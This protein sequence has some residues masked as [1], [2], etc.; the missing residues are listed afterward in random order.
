MSGFSNWQLPSVV[1]C[2]RLIGLSM[3]IALSGCVAYKDIHTSASLAAPESFASARTLPAQGGVWPALDWPARVGGT[4]LQD[5]VDEALKDNPGLQAAQTRLAAA[6]A[7]ADATRAAAGLGIGASAN[8]TYQRYTEHG[9]IPPPLAGTMHSDNQVALNFSYDFDFWG[10]HAADLRAVIAQGKSV[11]AEHYNARLVLATAVAR[12]W[13]QLGRQNQQLALTAQQKQVRQHLDDLTQRRIAAGLD[14][15]SDRQ[16]SQ[17]QLEQLNAE[18]AQWQEAIALTR[19]QLAALLGKG[20]DRGADIQGPVP[21]GLLPLDLP[22]SLPLQLIGR[23]PDVVAA[24]WQVEAIQGEIA[25]ARAQFYPNVNLNAFVGLSSLG[26]SNLLR[27]GSLIAGVGPAIRLP[28]FENGTLR[29]QLKGKVASYDGAVASYNQSITQALQ[30]VADQM[31]SL[32]GVA[33]QNQYQRNAVDAASKSLQLSQQ[34]QRVGTGNQLQVLASES[35]LLQQRRAEI[36]SRMR[37]L[38]LQVGLIKALGGGFDAATADLAI[39][40]SPTPAGAAT[41]NPIRPTSVKAAS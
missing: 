23:R 31:Q 4:A 14:T 18:Q 32:R 40:G 11:E 9:I 20:P 39:P 24:R 1:G 2:G 7:L 28:I 33:Q 34:R 19:D 30:D 37:I 12:T 6:S 41:T 38:D 10:K 3:S 5:L 13:L 36:D 27:S 8:S 15:Q 22:N 29:A 26:L 35:I 16:A 17:I 25:S 21:I